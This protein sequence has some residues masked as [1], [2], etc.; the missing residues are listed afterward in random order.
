MAGKAKRPLLTRR[1]DKLYLRIRHRQAW[2][3]AD[4]EPADSAGGFEPLRGH[5][6]ALLT[7]FRRSGEP[8]PTPVWFGVAEN[9]RLYFRS[10]AGVGKLKRIR[11]EPRVRLAPC[12]MRG[13]PLGPSVEG[14]AHILSPDEEESAERAIQAN[15][16]RFRKVYEGMG[17]R[18]G[19]EAKYVE[20]EPAAVPAPRAT[21]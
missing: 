15:Y 10:E 2:S 7:T 16:R 18:I 14:R 5:E 17:H 4:A 6:Y 3:S 21:A 12:T 8:V 9:G 13:K 1:S 19:V 20:V 11:N